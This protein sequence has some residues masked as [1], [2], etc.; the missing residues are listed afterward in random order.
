MTAESSPRPDVAALMRADFAALADKDLAGMQAL[1]H[2]QVEA[3]VLSLGQV[4]DHDGASAVFAELFSALDPFGFEA[5]RIH[6]DGNTSIGEWRMTGTFR[7]AWRGLAPTGGDLELCG[8]DVMEWEDRL[9]RR[10]TV[11]V[12]GAAVAR[13]LGL[14]PQRGSL[15]ERGL[16]AAF[17]G[18]QR[19][20]ARLGRI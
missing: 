15:A 6:A 12:D 19:V 9:L 20:R 8:V 18:V 3:H 5:V 16:T 1:W 2:P 13:Q 17:N 7:G 10:V 14:L 11:Y 4:L